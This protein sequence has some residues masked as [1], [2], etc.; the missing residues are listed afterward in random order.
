MMSKYV[1]WKEKSSYILCN[2]PVLIF[3]SQVS[4][5]SLTI[6]KNNPQVRYHAHWFTN[7][8]D[9]LAGYVF[10]RKGLQ[11][12]SCRQ[13]VLK[14]EVFYDDLN[15]ET[16]SETAAITVSNIKPLFEFVELNDN[17]FLQIQKQQND[18]GDRWERKSQSLSLQ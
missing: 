4:D 3:Y 2:R 1:N 16:I 7:V 5:E 18:Q 6:K 17:Y 15:F 12:F 14:I 9:I 11:T 10:S 13:D 8:F